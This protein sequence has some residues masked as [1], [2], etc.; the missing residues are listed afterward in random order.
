MVLAGAAS[1]Y[2]WRN[3]LRAFF[4][5]RWRFVLLCEAVFLVMMLFAYWLRIQNPDLFHP[6]EGGEKPMDLAYLNGVLRTTDL[7]QGAI[8]PWYSGGYLNYYWWG[9]FIASVPTKLLGI[10]PEVAYNLIVPMFFALSAAAAF[11][12]VYNLAE[13]TRRLM[14]RRPNRTR[15]GPTGPDHRGAARR[16]LRARCRELARGGCARRLASTRSAPGIRISRC[17]APS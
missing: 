16:L 14:R 10:V 6:T 15:I 13:G 7:T 11:S 8:D 12:V 2:V 5:E 9:F 3:D 1:A 4:G 17:S